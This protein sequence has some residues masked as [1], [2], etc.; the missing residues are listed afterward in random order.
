[1]D[2]PVATAYAFG[3]L[4]LRTAALCMAAPIFGAK[5]VPARVR[6]GLAMA[7]SFAVWSGAGA[8]AVAPPP[9]L[10]GLAAA[11]AS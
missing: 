1:V 9:G 4:L 2:L 5:V 7:L 3:L 8:P 11:A 10:L 6:L